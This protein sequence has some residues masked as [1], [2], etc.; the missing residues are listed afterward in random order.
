MKKILAIVSMAAMVAG[1][2]FAADAKASIQLWGSLVKGSTAEDSTVDFLT[3]NDTTQKDTDAFIFDFSGEKAG[4]HFQL[5]Y[6]SSATDGSAITARG[7]KIWFKPFDMLKVTVGNVEDGGLYKERITWWKVPVGAPLLHQDDWWRARWNGYMVSAYGVMA[8]IS[9]IAG[10]NITAAITPGK[11]TAFVTSAENSYTQYALIAKYQIMDSVSAGIGFCDNGYGS[12]KKL[13]FGADYS[14]SGLYAMLQGNLFF[15]DPNFTTQG[16]SDASKVWTLTGI[17]ID[18]YFE[19]STG[20]LKLQLTAPVTLRITDVEGDDSYM[21]LNFKASYG[22]DG[23]TPYFSIGTPGFVGSSSNA[24]DSSF[25]E[26]NLK[27]FDFSI[28][29]LPGVTFN[30]GEAAFDVGVGIVYN[31]A[32]KADIVTW[33][34]PFKVSIGF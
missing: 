30:V 3:V 10:L 34:I 8:E 32:D 24:E 20:A 9:P 7:A 4:G 23:F 25:T 14:A 1:A 17:C 21:S 16:W 12:Y 31:D 13:R 19:Y 28:A 33:A 18:N 11:D 5:Y 29:A 2:A 15:D 22:L 26:W 6:T 27:D